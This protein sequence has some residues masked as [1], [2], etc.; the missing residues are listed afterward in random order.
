MKALVCDLCGGKLV[1]GAGKIATCD[2]CGM[3]HSTERIKE[4]I[5]EIK[6]TV[7][8]DNAHLVDNYLSM[9]NDA[10]ES[11]NKKAAEEYCNKIIEVNPL[12]TNAL[13]L[14]GCAV[15]WQS[16]IGNFRFKE[17]AICF[18][19][20]TNTLDASEKEQIH[21]KVEDEFGKLATAL[22]QLRS[23]RFSKWQDQDEADGFEDDLEEIADAVELYEIETGLNISRN[24]VFRNVASI[25]R[26]CM[27]LV[28]TKILLNYRVDGSRRAYSQFVSQT[29]SCIQIMEKTAA[30]CDDDSYSDIQLYTQEV[31]MLE[32]LIENNST[33]AIQNRWGA[34]VQ[35]A[36]L[37]SYDENRKRTKIAELKSKIV[38]AENEINS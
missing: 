7:H 11:D 30:L 37:S 9:A 36:R 14:K 20:A 18:A 35:T 34:Y 16:S 10:Y 13:F 21:H 22:I 24:R 19:N 4:K 15:G 33:D 27:M 12:H 38:V 6:G 17:A 2:S 23:D 32:T 8:V 31:K 28:S 26:M 1:M 29:D 3:I 5:Q 25:V